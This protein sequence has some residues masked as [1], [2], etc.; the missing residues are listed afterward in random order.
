MFLEVDHN[1][2]SFFKRDGRWHRIFRAIHRPNRLE[3]P[4]EAWY[5]EVIVDEMSGDVAHS[6]SDPLAQH[7]GHGSDKTTEDRP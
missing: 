5:T 3:L 4:G 6:D 1:K 7:T 2:R